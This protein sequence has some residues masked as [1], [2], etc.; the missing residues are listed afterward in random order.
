MDAPFVAKWIGPLLNLPR[1]P[2]DAPHGSRSRRP[3][4]DP[5]WRDPVQRPGDRLQ[6]L[7]DPGQ[8]LGD[9]LR[10]LVGSPWAVVGL[11]A[12]AFGL[13]LLGIGR[14]S[15]WMDEMSTLITMEGGLPEAVPAS[16]HVHN[17]PPLYFVL[18][19]LWSAV[20]GT[21]D[22]VLRLPSVFFMA[23]CVPLL[24]KM[25][26]Q[27]AGPWAGFFAC[28]LF[29]LSP[30]V[31]RYAQE[32]RPYALYCFLSLVSLH[33]FLRLLDHRGSL[34]R[35]RTV[36]DPAASKR[37]PARRDFAAYG[38]ATLAMCATHPY[39]AFAVA[40]HMAVVG[41]LG[42]GL[43]K[44]FA[45][46]WAGV[47]LC[48]LPL[49]VSFAVESWRMTH[50]LT[51]PDVQ[52]WPG[53]GFAELLGLAPRLVFGPTTLWSTAASATAALALAAFLRRSI[54]APESRLRI[55]GTAMYAALTLLLPMLVTV[56]YTANIYA[57]RY[58]IASMPAVLLLCVSVFYRGAP[59]RFG[60]HALCGLLL[61]LA[62]PGAVDYHRTP[63]RIQWKE[64]ASFVDAR[65]T[66]N[67]A[68]LL[69]SPRAEYYL[70]ESWQR[71][72][73]D[74]SA[75]SQALVW[76]TDR[77]PQRRAD[78]RLE[79][80]RALGDQGSDRMWIVVAGGRESR[81]LEELA[82]VTDRFEVTRLATFEDVVVYQGVRKP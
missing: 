47:L 35:H 13:F 61:A 5:G 22:A 12:Q 44:A 29:M 55:V 39:A 80:A 40:A 49:A 31:L 69:Y 51:S 42:A 34:D 14:D 77:A 20:A 46:T 17:H 53:P 76:N 7:G 2:V 60:A 10:R 33:L 9:T 4:G 28:Q 3:V 36:A 71:Y 15:L 38:V 25:A 73:P 68:V 8:R 23:A 57:L 54:R 24:H 41:A 43:R 74:D 26:R 11:T 75:A 16:M 48:L 30:V 65:L 70:H 1:E 56:L 19:W 32:A 45:R 82:A 59:R 78:R 67:D 81:P 6:R 50:F 62:V 66:P 72:Y 52:L 18:L 79:I 27:A 58:F 37:L 21:S 64:A 63:Q